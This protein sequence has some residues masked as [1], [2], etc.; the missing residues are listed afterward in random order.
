MGNEQR[1]DFV[2]ENWWINQLM[3][4][5]F[6]IIRLY[7]RFALLMLLLSVASNSILHIYQ[8]Q[9]FSEVTFCFL[10]IDSSLSINSKILLHH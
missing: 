5:V 9:K 1:K 2:K 6:I 7:L 4:R 3:N 8:E 10:V